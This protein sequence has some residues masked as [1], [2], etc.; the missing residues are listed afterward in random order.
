MLRRYGDGVG[1]IVRIET[2]EVV[3]AVLV[4]RCRGND[5]AAAVTQLHHHAFDGRVARARVVGRTVARI[6]IEEDGVADETLIGLLAAR[7]VAEVA[8]QVVGIA[9]RQR[10]RIRDILTVAFRT[11]VGAV[12][13]GQ[14]AQNIVAVRD[15]DQ[16]VGAGRTRAVIQRQAGEEIVAGGVGGVGGNHLAVV[17]H[18]VAVGVQRQGHG[19]ARDAGFAAIER[20]V[21][22]L[23]KP[24][25]V[26]D[27]PGGAAR[28]IAEVGVQEDVAGSQN[29]RCGG[30]VVAGLTGRR[31]AEVVRVAGLGVAGRRRYHDHVLARPAGWTKM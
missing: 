7:R 9:R 25:S 23:I 5:V 21:G 31:C 24:D 3:V 10:N 29:H 19:D 4:G 26:A 17:D 28:L 14:F 15:D 27:G 30:P 18:A 22:I 6:G 2:A 8:G 11:V 12:G 16:V 1:H 20:A 13:L